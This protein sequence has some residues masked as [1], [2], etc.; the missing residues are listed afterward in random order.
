MKQKSVTNKCRFTLIELLVV[1]AI[2]AILAAIL[3]PALNAARQRGRMASCINNLK[4]FGTAMNMYT[5]DNDDRVPDFY[6]NGTGDPANATVSSFYNRMDC[7][8]GLGKLYASPGRNDASVEG[9]GYIADKNVFLCPADNFGDDYSW[10]KS[11][12]NIRGAY[13]MFNTYLFKSTAYINAY[14]LADRKATNFSSGMIADIAADNMPL[15]SE[16]IPG[17]NVANLT[18]GYSSHVKSKAAD[19][20]TCYADG[21]VVTN[22]ITEADFTARGSGIDVWLT[23]WRGM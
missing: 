12:D 6:W 19:F 8:V 17:S 11:S 14:K 9:N 13:S 15:I 23:T 22:E 2:I 7:W 1:I 18:N 3:L 16:R 20:N 5:Q 10:G 21:H 4:Q